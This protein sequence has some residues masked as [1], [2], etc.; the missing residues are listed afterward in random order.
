MSCDAVKP[1]LGK[2]FE[3][4]R[5]ANRVPGQAIGAIPVTERRAAGVSAGD[6]VRDHGVPTVAEPVIEPVMQQAGC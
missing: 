4:Q 1:P 6:A 3:A 5:V 2:C